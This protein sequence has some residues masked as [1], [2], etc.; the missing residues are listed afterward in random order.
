MRDLQNMQ[1]SASGLLMGSGMDSGLLV[2]TLAIVLWISCIIAGALWVLFR[3]VFPKTRNDVT[4]KLLAV[5]NVTT[6]AIMYA[7]DADSDINLYSGISLAI[8]FL[9]AL[10]WPVNGVKS[11]PPKL[12]RRN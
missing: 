7:S 8:A 9:L 12:E 5:S 1:S 11:S 6:T 10:P 4:G 3:V 2:A